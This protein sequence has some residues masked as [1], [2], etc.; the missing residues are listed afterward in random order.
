MADERRQGP[1]AVHIMVNAGALTGDLTAKASAAP[2]SQLPRACALIAP[3][4]ATALP[5]GRF[6]SISRLIR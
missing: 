4:Y 5:K 3:L 2:M 1:L 6:S